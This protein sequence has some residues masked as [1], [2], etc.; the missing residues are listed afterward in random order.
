M[1]LLREPRVAGLARSLE[2]AAVMVHRRV[3]ASLQ[4]RI[5]R[6]DH[7]W[8]I[9]IALAL[10][11]A[12]TVALI[13][14]MRFVELQHVSSAYLVPVLIAAT[15]LGVVPAIVVAIGGIASAA[16]FFYP[17][18]YD[19]HVSNPAQLLDLPLF[20]IVA[21]VTGHL[22]SRG[23][24]QAMLAQE[25]ESETRA[26]YAFSKRLAVVTDEVEIYSAIQ[27]HLSTITDCP[28]VYFEPDA[29]ASPSRHGC[30]GATEAV[31][32]AV[33]EVA[34]QRAG[35][36]AA[37]VRDELTGALW[38]I[39]AVSHKSAA[40]GVAAIDVGRTSKYAHSTM[41]ARIDAVLADASATLERLDVAKA[42]GEAK[43]RTEAD[44][45]RAALVGSVSHG[46]RTPLA[47]IMGSASILVG[48][49]AIAR[50]PRLAEL[51]CIIRDEAERLD[52]DIQR[53]LDASR[54]SSV[55]VRPHLAWADAADVVN[56][57]VARQHRSLASH[58]VTV[59][60][61]DDLPLVSVDP[62]LIEQAL[63]QILDNAAKYS[64]TGSAIG[65]ETRSSGG[66][67]VI[68]VTDQGAGF[69]TEESGRAFER[70]YRGSRTSESTTGSGLG[71]WIARAFVVA[72]GGRLEVASGGVGHGSSIAILIP[73]V[74]MPAASPDGSIDE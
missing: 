3:L 40:F 71:L 19:F 66:Q 39:R 34:R 8:S 26:L 23:R 69:S 59:C 46:L 74:E 43:L 47:S 57:A 28:V 62:V 38:F 15:M 63:S 49:P 7:V 56:A 13:G 67:L 1:V 48:A 2:L 50:E 11:A 14:V 4:R 5:L 31:R 16:F 17:P 70:F 60:V 36:S 72:C 73:A 37:W 41:Q 29:A 10:V 20:L 9:S 18:I 44:T 35:G 42:I 55:G 12:T 45:L 53:L 22:A 6:E 68:A 54:I 32:R 21:T 33:S 64:P 24:A 25:R 27:D 52:G 65:V 58:H 61:A 30:S 51:A